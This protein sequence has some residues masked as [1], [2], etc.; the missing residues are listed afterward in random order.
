MRVARIFFVAVWVMHQLACGSNGSDG[1]KRDTPNRPPKAPVTARSVDESDLPA[2]DDQDRLQEAHHLL[3][4][5]GNLSRAKEI[6]AQVAESRAAPVDVRARAELQMAELAEIAGDR[7]GALN[8]L[9]RAKIVAGPGHSL[10]LEADD[11]RARIIA[12]APLA[13]VRGPVPGSVVLRHEQPPV[14]ANFRR[15]E[16]L[17]A[18]YHRVIVAPRLEDMNE[19]L[20][21]KK[22]ALAAAVA[23]YQRVSKQGGNAAK[24]AALFRIGAMYHHLAEALVFAIPSE[25]LPSVARRFRRQYKIESTAHLRKSL[26]HYQEA[27]RVPSSPGTEPWRELAR[28]EASTLEIVLQS[29]QRR[30]A[31]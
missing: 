28:R 17:L 24:A 4:V 19:V 1:D 11:R 21:S 25:L 5:S 6:L 14:V 7:R 18:A 15:A 27:S 9:E 2:P 29:S 8:H 13:E 12:V 30:R 22:R 26:E 23:G 3:W 16:R 20:Q 31:K 10:A